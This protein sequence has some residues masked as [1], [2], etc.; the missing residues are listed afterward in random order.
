[1]CVYWYPYRPCMRI[2]IWAPEL[3]AHWFYFKLRRCISQ[4]KSG[5]I[6]ACMSVDLR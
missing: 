2:C 1:M 6:D 3:C 5:Q 4:M